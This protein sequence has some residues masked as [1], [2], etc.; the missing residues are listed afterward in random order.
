ML[1]PIKLI[2]KKEKIRR[3][4]TSLVFIQYCFNSEKRTVLNTQLAIP[5]TY[6]NRKRQCI[7]ADLPL[8]FGKAEDLNGQLKSMVRLAEDIVSFAGKKKIRCPL[9]FLKRNFIPDFD[10]SSLEERYPSGEIPIV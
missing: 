3:D 10:L 7:T 9:T 8:I 4:G 1:L 5:P 2:C 6:W